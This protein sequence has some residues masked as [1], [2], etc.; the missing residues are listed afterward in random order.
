MALKRSYATLEEIPEAQRALYV[1]KDGKYVLD[2]DADGDDGKLAG[3]LE[4]ERQQRKTIEKTLSDL[5][6]NLDGLDPAKAREA[7]A[8]LAELEEKADLG[9]IPE[10]LK[11]KIDA[12][13]RKRTD[14]MATDYQTRL[15]AAEEK[16]KGANS[17]L[18]ELLIDNA[19][20]AE[21]VK[22]GVRSTAVDDV[23]LYGRTVFRLKDGK[24]VPMKGEEV[25]YGKEPNKPLTPEEW[26]AERSKD[27][28]HWFEASG[29]GGT[30]PAGGGRQ[31]GKDVSLT[32]DEAKDPQRYRAAKEQAAKAGGQV[33]IAAP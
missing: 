6:K 31:T 27:R 18:E 10:G 32:R 33:I 1:E 21:A 16:L 11:A 12:I 26:I 7:L 20:R 15:T 25:L 29:G 3:A 8:T 2:L 9:E 30:P 13:V 19:L 24:P 22:H 23:V 17:Q 28:P 14:R 5:R 4:K